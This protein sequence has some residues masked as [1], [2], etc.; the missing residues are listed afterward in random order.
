MAIFRNGSFDPLIQRAS[1]GHICDST[2]YLLMS[3]TGCV[4]LLP[5][6]VTCVEISRCFD[7]VNICLWTDGS[8]TTQSAAQTACQ[9][10]S[11]SF[12]PRITNMNIQNSL[13]TFRSTAHGLLGGSGFWVDVEAVAISSFQWIDGSSMA[14]LF[15]LHVHKYDV[16]RQCVYYL[17]VLCMRNSFI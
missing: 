15:C 14:G 8:H 3:I 13:A 10:R 7:N 12:L 1:R 5:R 17:F 16:I 11:N 6:Q 2:A 9:R 4:T